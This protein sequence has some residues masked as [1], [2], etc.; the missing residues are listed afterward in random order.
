MFIKRKCIFNT[1]KWNVYT[2]TYISIPYS[3][4]EVIVFN[5]VG[6]LE[7][8]WLVYLARHFTL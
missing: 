8:F 1:V 3:Y 7:L 6:I 2:Y 4:N 5:V